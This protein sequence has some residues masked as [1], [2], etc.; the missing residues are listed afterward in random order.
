[1]DLKI[2]SLDENEI[3][4][5]VSLNYFDYIFSYVCFNSRKQKS[6]KRILDTALKMIDISNYINIV[7]QNSHLYGSENK[8]FWKKWWWLLM[9]IIEY[10]LI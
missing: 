10:I 1:M 8:D 9:K 6:Y 4:K 3:K 2:I 5:T 7:S